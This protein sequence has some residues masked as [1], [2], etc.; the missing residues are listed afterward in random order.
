MTRI[1]KIPRKDYRAFVDIVA[2]AY[3]GMQINT[4]DEKDRSRRL[5]LDAGHRAGTHHFGA[6]QKGELVGVMAL[7]DFMMNLDGI[8]VP[9][10]GI[11]LVAVDLLH[12]K[13]KICRDMVSYFIDRYHR[14]NVHLLALYPF[15][16]DFYKKMGF[17][18][19]TLVN[20]YSVRPGDLPVTH[21][22]AKVRFLC[23]R[24]TRS[25][26]ACYGRFL[27]QR[28]G[29]MTDRETKWLH[30]FDNPTIKIVGYKDGGMLRGYIIFTF[31]KAHETNW[32][33]NDIV[34]RE[35]IYESGEA[36]SGLVAFLRSQS[37]Q[38]DRIVYGTQEEYFHLILQDTRSG[39][40]N[41]LKPLAHETNTQ[42]IGVMYRVI[43]IPGIFRS[44]AAH[45]F[46]PVTV[47]LKITITDSFYTSNSGS[48]V[49]FFKDGKP[50]IPK[51]KRFD[52]EIMLDISDFSS[53]FMGAVD[54]LHL[55]RFGLA[56]ISHKR[57]IQTVDRLF[58]TCEKPLCMTQF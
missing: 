47:C 37:D 27:K 30:L 11:G 18:Y 13:E 49:I 55:Y 50:S 52:A 20:Q 6:Y 17:G 42:G 46:G 21:G 43:D 33:K 41:L 16:P 22:K 26:K 4:R 32:I 58:R 23:K 57:F 2:N 8:M 36:F 19:G 34:I 31:R 10:G 53:L 29:M 38:I 3:P 15:R 1:K 7:Y 44:L 48:T 14:Q 24:D 25:I 12:K 39:S 54:F 40:E 45:R 9:V 35:F 28:H 5:L 56:D 51:G